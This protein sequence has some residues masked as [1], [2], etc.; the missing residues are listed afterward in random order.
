MSLLRGFRKQNRDS[1]T[2]QARSSVSSLSQRIMQAAQA[3]AEWTPNRVFRIAYR[4]AC[5]AI[6]RANKYTDKRLAEGATA[7]A[8]TRFFVETDGY[9][10]IDA[11]EDAGL[12]MTDLR[13]KYPTSL[14]GNSSWLG[15]GTGASAEATVSEGV[16]QHTFLIR[17]KFNIFSTASKIRIRL[18]MRVDRSSTG[19]RDDILGEI[20]VRW[21]ESFVFLDDYDGGWFNIPASV[22]YEALDGDIFR[23]SLV[24]TGLPGTAEIEVHGYWCAHRVGA[25]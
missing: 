4:L 8:P 5:W 3:A 9:Q 11:N 12:F 1:L 20:L 24:V 17:C 6:R 22:D 21:P 14:L 23:P 18:R 25:L 2:F 7:A 13:Y 16:W 10:V 19:I 15:Y